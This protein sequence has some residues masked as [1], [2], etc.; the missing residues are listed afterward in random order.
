VLWGAPTER[1]L[2]FASPERVAELRDARVGETV[3][4]AVA[5]VPFYREFLGRGAR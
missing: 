2:P 1:R 4:Y 3:A 5:H